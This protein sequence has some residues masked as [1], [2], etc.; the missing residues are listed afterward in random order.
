M[1]VYNGEWPEQITKKLK[2]YPFETAKLL[3]HNYT[4]ERTAVLFSRRDYGS[5]D[6]KRS[7]G[8]RRRGGVRSETKGMK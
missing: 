6:L 7:Q 1:I 3:Y 5:W 4:A 2:L 8:R